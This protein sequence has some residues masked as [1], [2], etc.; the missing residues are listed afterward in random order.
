MTVNSN[1]HLLKIGDIKIYLRRDV[2]DDY[3]VFEGIFFA[4]EYYPLKLKKSDIVLDVGANIGAFTL[5]VAPKVKHVIAVEPEPNN[6]EILKRNVNKNNLSNVT[7]LN[8]AVSDKAEIVYFNTTG[9]SAKVS[10]RGIPINAKPLDD[11]LHELGE[12]EVTIMKMDIEGYEGKVLSAFKNYESLRQIIMEVHSRDL[13]NYVNKWLSAR[14]FTVV[15]VSRIKKA[16]VVK[17][18]F[19][20]LIP[21]LSAERAYNYFTIKQGIK[22]LLRLA[23]SPVAVVFHQIISLERNDIS[24]FGMRLIL[25][26][27][28]KFS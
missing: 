28:I 11:I 17:N 25:R 8:Y 2:I 20:N 7:L 22:Y 21:F 9:G 13:W 5:K 23:P 3:W 14:G 1:L 15:D 4:D 19:S 16:R 10:D 27:T 24:S 18:I 26:K 12:S 6:F